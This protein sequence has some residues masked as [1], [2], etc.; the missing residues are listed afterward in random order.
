MS[1]ILPRTKT[2]KN[3]EILHLRS[4]KL[5]DAAEIIHFV[6]TVGGETDFLT[7]GTG[8]FNKTVAEEETIISEHLAAPNR[9]FIA[10]TLQDEI[11]GILNVTASPKPRLQHSGE[12]GISVLKKHWGKGIG[13]HLM[14]TMLDWAERSPIIRKLNL[15]VLTSNTKA[16]A[17]YKSIGFEEEGYLKEDTFVNGVYQDARIMAYFS[18][19]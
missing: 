10:A 8:E 2:L 18:K 19:S 11:V 15:K 17:L 12:F 4:V 13:R 14:E 6:K 1:T 9:I 16:L 5:A 3:G 7:F